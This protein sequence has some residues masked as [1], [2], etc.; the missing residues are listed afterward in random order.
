MT[1]SGSA[2][3]RAR[4]AR[5]GRHAL[6]LGT[7]STAAQ[8][9]DLLGARVK[10]GLKVAVRADLRGDARAG[11]AARHPADHAGRDAGP[12]PHRR[13][14]RRDRRRAAAHQGRRRRAAAREDRGHC[15]RA[16]GR[17]RRCLQAGRDARQ[18]S[19]PRRGGAL[20]PC[21]HAQHGRGARR[22]GG[23]QGRDQAAS[24]RRTASRSSTDGGN[25]ILDCAVR[26]HR[27]ARGAGRGTE[28]ECR[29]W[30]RTACSSASP[31]SP[32]SRDPTAS[33]RSRAIPPQRADRPSH[34]ADPAE[35]T[36]HAP[37]RATDRRPRRGLAL[38]PGVAACAVARSGSPRGGAAS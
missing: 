4:L 2:G 3:R 11:R 30:W 32:S 18:V 7:G 24:R 25:H 37:A 29:A 33:S 16:H 19:A 13:R 21:R 5:R 6:G 36:N 14:R 34:L 28:A 22:R 38:G 15:L 17:D 8:F 31:I 12:R 23:M 1:R 10:A 20:R 9:V 27:R 26:P 35:G